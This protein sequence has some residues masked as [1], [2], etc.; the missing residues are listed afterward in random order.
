MITTDIHSH[1]LPGIDDGSPDVKTSYKMIEK[2]IDSGIKTIVCTPHFVPHIDE[3]SEFIDRRAKSFD[4]IKNKYASTDIDIRL[5]AEVFLE[6]DISKNINM[7]DLCIKGT[8]KLL[9]ELPL[10][11]LNTWMI[12][13]I[14]NISHKFKIV[15]I[16]A[17]IERYMNFYSKDDFGMILSIP[18]A[19][20]QINAN[21]FFDRKKKNFIKGLYKSGIPLVFGS[22]CHNMTTRPPNIDILNNLYSKQKSVRV[23]FDKSNELATKIL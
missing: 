2:S 19:I 21:S 7:L 9:I 3:K 20:Y 17:H 23:F 1:I 15:P 11:N 12:Q 6:L 5:G 4:S 18:N 13:E 14:E 8:N 16:I 10:L 22:D